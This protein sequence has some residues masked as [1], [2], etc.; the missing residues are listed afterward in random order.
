MIVYGTSISPFAR[1]VLFC[2]A[3][4]GLTTD[5]VAIPPHDANEGFR[6]CSPFG[7]LPGFADGDFRMAD[8]S[9]ICHYLEKKYP[10][11]PIFPA[12]PEGFARVV[13]FEEFSDTI[14]FAAVG[15]IFGN[16]FVKPRLFKME[17]DMVAVEQGISELPALFAYL[18]SQIDGPFLVGDSLT[19][20]DMAVVCPFVNLGMVGHS[21]DPAT[22]PKLV[23]YIAGIQARPAFVGIRD[24]KPQ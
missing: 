5:H 12:T 11:N 16:L 10:A 18:E 23:A 7:K 22:Y 13:W 15:K 4:K 6:A 2:I 1:K 21:P 14:M 3:E 8:S 17:P 9:A 20:A 19:L 24:P